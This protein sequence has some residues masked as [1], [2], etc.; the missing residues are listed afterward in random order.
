MGARRS[1]KRGA[2]L[3]RRLEA[4]RRRFDASELSPDPLE[5]PHRFASAADREVVGFVAAAIAY[6]NVRTI[7]Q[8]MEVLLRWMG[9][10]PSLFARNF[11]PHRDLKELG[12]FQHRWSRARDVACLVA[13]LGQMQERDGSIG[14]FFRRGYRPGDLAHSLQSFSSRSL[15][16][17]HCGIYRPRSLPR[18]AGVRFFFTSPKTGACKRLNMYLRWMVR[19]N[20]GLDFGLWTFM[21]PAELLIPLDTHIHRIGRHL[22]WTNRQTPGWRAAQDITESLARVDAS[23]PTKY[24][25][26]LSRMGIR[27]NCPRHSTKDEC[28][29]CDLK[30]N[31]RAETP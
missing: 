21:S 6:G 26:A 16:L 23:D 10:E 28:D 24:D 7:C 22:G 2:V 30:G 4:L 8:S 3:R 29:L 15:A 5:F 18:S 25:F 12:R 27:E 17:D 19:P 20:D 31:R 1:V 13:F 11:S 14:A 9:P